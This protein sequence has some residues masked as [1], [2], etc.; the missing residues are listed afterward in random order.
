M[1]STPLWLP[2]ASGGIAVLGTLGGVFITQ[3][4]ADRREDKAWQRKRVQNK[5]ISG[6]R[7]G[8]RITCHC[9]KRPMNSRSG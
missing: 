9:G 4:W 1:G 6:L 2:L 5:R 8:G 7:T 3:W